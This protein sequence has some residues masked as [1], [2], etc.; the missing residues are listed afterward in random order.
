LPNLNPIEMLWANVGRRLA[1]RDFHTE[2]VLMAEV[3]LIGEQS[4]D[5]GI[6]ASGRAPDSDRTALS[7]T[8]ICYWTL[9]CRQTSPELVLPGDALPEHLPWREPRRVLRLSLVGLSFPSMPTFG[10]G[11][12]RGP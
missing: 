11:A 4:L 1:W 12:R 10:L 2:K 7:L 9:L 8:P 6:R 3:M 5:A